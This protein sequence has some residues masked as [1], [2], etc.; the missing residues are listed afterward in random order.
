MS[1]TRRAV[2][3]SVCAA[4][5][6]ARKLPDVSWPSLHVTPPTNCVRPKVTGTL[7]AGRVISAGTGV[8]AGTEP[9]VL[10]YQ[11][12]R[13]GRPIGSA[14]EPIYTL[15]KADHGARVT[16]DVV[17]RNAFGATPSCAV[18]AGWVVGNLLSRCRDLAGGSRSRNALVAAGAEADV[19]METTTA[20]S[21]SVNHRVE[22]IIEPKKYR[23]QFDAEG[24]W[25]PDW[26]N[27]SITD[28]C[29]GSKLVANFNVTT[30]K[31]GI[32]YGLGTQSVAGSYS[33]RALSNGNVRCVRDWVSN[34]KMIASLS[35]GQ[36]VAD[37]VNYYTG[38]SGKGNRITN[39]VMLE[40]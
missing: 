29:F 8:W 33:V 22:Q 3:L 21:H 37:N 26:I 7:M 10:S 39:V 27:V 40:L 1:F 24:G 18:P 16:C 9:I 31:T 25:G 30:L 36:A 35:I 19:L 32:T 5:P 38:E 17:G 13:E 28:E 14:T 23:V 20:A 6:A 12:L 4:L 34:Q 2:L 11:W 15:T